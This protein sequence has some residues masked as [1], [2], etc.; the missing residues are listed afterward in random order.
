VEGRVE[1]RHDE[2][3][4]KYEFNGKILTSVTTKLQRLNKPH[5]QKWKTVKAIEWLEREDRWERLK[6]PTLK[7]EDIIN[8]ALFAPD[9]IRDDAGNVGT[10]A[11][12]IIE[13]YVNEW[14]ST[15]Q[16]PVDIRNFCDMTKTDPRA[17][18]SARA[19]EAAFRKHNVQ[20]I[21]CELLVGHPKWS[22][23]TL[24]FLC[25]WDGKLCLADFKTSNSVSDDYAMQTAAYKYMFEHMT[26]VKISTIKIMHFSKDND[27]FTIYNVKKVS[28]AWK[29]FK[30][31]CTV[32]DWF[33]NRT[34]KLEKDI[35]RLKI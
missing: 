34:K 2:Y 17:I 5:L 33:N 24:D 25:I 8:A 13:R 10:Q 4:H 19:A 3:G 23:G 32:D 35:R 16:M 11:H 26:K 15:G 9:S 30:A 27:S 14:V 7:R 29:A 20:P 18:A 28:E 22:A 21:A 6:D 31:I 1:A 12:N